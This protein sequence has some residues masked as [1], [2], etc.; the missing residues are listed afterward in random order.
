MP[1]HT[2]VWSGK[3][4]RHFQNKITI[5]KRLD[6]ASGLLKAGF[7]GTQQGKAKK[8]HVT[9]YNSEWAT[10]SWNGSPKVPTKLAHKSDSKQPQWKHVF[11]ANLNVSSLNMIDNILCMQHFTHACL[12]AR[13]SR[14]VPCLTGMG[15][16]RSWA[17]LTVWS[18]S[19]LCHLL[20]L[21]WELFVLL[22][23]PVLAL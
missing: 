7:T 15:M 10:C 22:R 13:V 12:P 8:H 17:M 14:S 5:K 4:G 9:W 21:D 18:P 16:G 23:C 3:G 6:S 1:K 2:K 11:V 19:L 20:M